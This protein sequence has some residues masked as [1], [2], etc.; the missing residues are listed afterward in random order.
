MFFGVLPQKET[1]EGGLKYGSFCNEHRTQYFCKS[2]D[3]NYYYKPTLGV[4]NERSK[5]M[6]LT[7]QVNSAMTQGPLA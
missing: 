2:K 7:S 4:C 1:L 6:N 5:D 3:L